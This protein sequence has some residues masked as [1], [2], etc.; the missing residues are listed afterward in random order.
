M[1]EQQLAQVN[2]Y[3]QNKKYQDEQAAKAKRGDAQKKPLTKSPFVF[4]FEYGASAE[5]YWVYEHMV[6]Q[7][8]DCVD[9]LTVL[10]PDYE[11]LFLLDH[12]CGHDRQ[13]EDGLNVE[14]MNKSYGGNKP[15]MRDTKIEQEGVTLDLTAESCIL[16]TLRR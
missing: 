7:L 2:E 10:F 8:E 6:L 3:R 15:K 16:E 9:C 14:N 1:N 12:S 5:G 4:K 13:R 11:F